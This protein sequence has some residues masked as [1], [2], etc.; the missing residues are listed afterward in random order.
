M[1]Y[2]AIK[3][4]DVTTYEA[5]TKAKEAKDE[6]AGAAK[7]P[8]KGVLQGEPEKQ[9]DVFTAPEEKPGGDKGIV[10]R[11]SQ[12]SSVNFVI[13]DIEN[14]NYSQTITD[15]QGNQ[16]HLI[17]SKDGKHIAYTD[18]PSVFDLEHKPP[19]EK[20]KGGQ[21]GLEKETKGDLTG[22]R[23]LDQSGKRSGEGEADRD[24]APQKATPE[25]QKAG[26][27]GADHI[28]ALREH[29][30]T[31]KLPAGTAD[32]AQKLLNQVAAKTG[33]DIRGISFEDKSRELDPTNE[34]H[35]KT[36]RDNSI[37]EEDIND[38]IDKEEVF[39]ITGQHQLFNEEGETGIKKFSVITL[40]QGAGPIDVWHEGGGHAHDEQGLLPRVVGGDKEQRA[41]YLEEMFL[42][43]KEGDVSGLYESE[44]G[45][46][47]PAEVKYHITLKEG[48]PSKRDKL[49][50]RSPGLKEFFKGNVPH[51]IIRANAEGVQVRGGDL[52]GFSLPEGRST[53]R[54]SSDDVANFKPTDGQLGAVTGPPEGLARIAN[55]LKNWFDYAATQEMTGLTAE[56]KSRGYKVE[57]KGKDV[58]HDY[59]GMNPLAAK[60]MGFTL[61]DGK[62]MPDDVI[63][64]D[65]GADKSTNVKTLRHELHEMALMAKGQPYFQAHTESLKHETADTEK[66]LPIKGATDEGKTSDTAGKKEVRGGDGKAGLS[67]ERT[68]GR[69]RWISESRWSLRHRSAHQLP[70]KPQSKRQPVD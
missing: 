9:A 70:R 13:K 60:A 47:G 18:D 45:E 63:Y 67:A 31:G 53:G 26:T 61:P 7:E 42:A 55:L 3:K 40:F 33:V 22:D 19:I 24:P 4:G 1:D 54:V 14:W 43:E 21:D 16:T 28:A 65:S 51:A 25:E 27:A 38:A 49:I 37:T 35:L 62:P 46:A 15:E 30:K 39:I 23:G 52:R 57:N 5:R 2:I 29:E 50:A 66:L 36:L 12:D 64:L 10:A 17:V 44:A 32:A 41:A 68:G 11:N 56:A 69:R 58:L 48:G 8:D 6:Q 59:A 20:A 34:Q